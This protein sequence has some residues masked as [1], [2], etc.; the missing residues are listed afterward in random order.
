MVEIYST[1]P[2]LGELDRRATDYRY[3]I[4]T[5]ICW[6]QLDDPG[7]MMPPSVLE[8][9]GVDVA[10]LTATGSLELYDWC[11]G[12]LICQH[13]IELERVVIKWV[14]DNPALTPSKSLEWLFDEEVKHI[15]TF[16]RYRKHLLAQRPEEAGLAEA[17]LHELHPP[18]HFQPEGDGDLI[19]L[20]YWTWITI[21]AFEEFTVHLYTMLRDAPERIQP[22]WLGVHHCHAQEEICHVE[23]DRAYVSALLLE[24]ED[25]SARSKLFVSWLLASYTKTFRVAGRVS[26][27]RPP[28]AFL[29]ALLTSPDFAQ[30]RSCAPYLDWLAERKR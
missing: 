24:H 20:H 21:L 30:T 22:A 17:L 8:A 11:F 25:L 10:G 12:L 15:K 1:P 13:F 29:D 14:K 4:E 16:R 27:G 6:D 26:L 23:T 18:G 2:N 7:A 19:G 28:K 5:D 3:D 9:L